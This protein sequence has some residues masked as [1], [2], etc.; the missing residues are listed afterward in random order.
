MKPT[1]ARCAHGTVWFRPCAEC[2]G[3]WCPEPVSLDALITA[4]RAERR[5][6]RG[7]IASA[8]LATGAGQT[9]TTLRVRMVRAWVHG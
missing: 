4:D 3:Y 8:P 6:S 5:L 1:M 9:G 7:V 2:H